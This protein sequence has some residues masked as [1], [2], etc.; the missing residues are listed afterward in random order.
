MGVSHKGTTNS[1][2]SRSQNVEYNRSAGAYR[3]NATLTLKH[4]L[5][6][7]FTLPRPLVAFQC[8][9]CLNLSA[10]LTEA[11]SGGRAVLGCRRTASL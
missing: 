5:A 4:C 1:T 9:R 3:H 2:A 11:F 7:S 10:A 6:S 8:F